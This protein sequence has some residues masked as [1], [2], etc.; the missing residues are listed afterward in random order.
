LVAKG[1][2]V[3]L[4]GT[5]DEIVARDRKDMNRAVAPLRKADDAIAI[6][7]TGLTLDEV[8]DRMVGFVERRRAAATR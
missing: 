7:S 5:I 1:L 2:A 3:D 4:Q 6:D 8:V